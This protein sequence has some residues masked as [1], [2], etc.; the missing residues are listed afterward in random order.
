M[1]VLKG[2]RL[3]VIGPFFVLDLEGIAMP[4]AEPAQYANT[5]ELA[6]HL[7]TSGTTI[8][9]WVQEGRIPCLRCSQRVLRFNTAEVLAALRAR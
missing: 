2:D 4:I 9:R 6:E 8:R 7:N 1:D 3:R 5:A